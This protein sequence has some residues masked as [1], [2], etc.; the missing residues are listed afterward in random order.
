MN[1]RTATLIPTLLILSFL[2]SSLPSFADTTDPSGNDTT[3]TDPTT[4]GT[5]DTETTDAEKPATLSAEALDIVGEP[6]TSP[7]PTD[8]APA[9]DIVEPKPT[10]N[11]LPESPTGTVQSLVTPSNTLAPETSRTSSPAEEPTPGT[12]APTPVSPATPDAPTLLGSPTLIGAGLPQDGILVAPGMVSA[13]FPSFQVIAISLSTA[14]T[15]TVPTVIISEVQT[16]GTDAGGKI[17]GADEFIELY[18]PGNDVA[19][20]AGLKLCRKTSGTTTSQI[21]SFSESDTI[22]GKG[23]FLFANSDGKFAPKADTATKSSPLAKDNGIA[24]T[25]NCSSPT[26]I[27]DSLAWGTGKSF[28]M[29]TPRMENPPA[30]KSLVRDVETLTWSVSDCP[31]PTNSRGETTSPTDVC[32]KPVPPPPV[33]TVIISEL[34]PNPDTGGE[35]WIEIHNTGSANVSLAGWKLVDAIGKIY[36]FPKGSAIE[37]GGF[38]VV[39]GKTS[40]I[41]LNNDKETVSLLFPDESV[42]DTFQYVQTEK[43]ESWAR[44]D[45]GTFL[46]THTPTPGTSNMFD[47]EEKPI[48]L[49]DAGTIIVNEFLPYPNASEEEWI[50]LR[51]T[52]DT[53]VSIAGWKLKDASVSGG[54][55]F[56][57]MTTIGPDGYL[58]IG[59]DISK[60][61]LNNTGAES[62]TLSFPD[63]SATDTYSY[64]G[65]EQGAAYARTDA[66]TFLLTHT[67]TPGTENAFDPEEKPAW[68]PPVGTIIISELF[69]NPAQKGEGNEWIELRNTGNVPVSLIGWMLQSGSGKFTWTSGL[70][71]TQ[72]GIVADGFLVIERALSKLAL[73]NTD[74][75]VTLFAPGGVTTMDTVTYSKTIEEASYGFFGPGRFRWSKTP[76]PGAENIF[77]TEPKVKRSSIPRSGYVHALIPFSADGNKKN[78]KYS[79]DFGDGHRSYLDT[80]GH[81]YAK[82]GTY[83]GTLTASDGIEE[84][85]KTF[86][87]RIGRYPKWDVHLVGLCPNPSGTDTGSEWIRIRNDDTKRISLAGWSIATATEK[88]KLV[89]HV[90]LSDRSIAPGEEIVLTHDDSRFT[91]PNERAVIELRR[92][93][94]K[95]VQT[96]DYIRDG[97]AEDD[98]IFAKTSDSG[99]AWSVPAAETD[100]LAVEMAATEEFEP[101][102][103]GMT[104]DQDSDRLTFG[105]FVSLG[106]PYDP[107]LP[108]SLPRVL[109]ASDER[110]KDGPSS[111][112]SFIDALFRMLNGLATG[113]T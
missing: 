89:N 35:E 49:P 110:L 12:P 41:A 82:T 50:E 29:D 66:G 28:D 24:L 111:S 112:E 79:W 52:S 11:P 77:G 7:T 8:P 59:A 13:I 39:D 17:I 85:V 45:A 109:G 84:T 20:L 99:W 51:N 64:E 2:V 33:G 37:A 43:N 42:A 105:E 91:L 108:D 19:P 55:T 96:V 40:G 1:G 103:T 75:A 72:S 67:P 78:M 6:A 26:R 87:I 34:F 98:A 61:A 30:D 4:G 62:I 14:D 74:G 10:G 57:P 27:I 73:R 88:E 46:L 22:P 21:K 56:P 90:V 70:S 44:T 106:T 38:L 80:T 9:H 81:R 32:L 86:T 25:D 95:T 48:P 54:Y 63:G 31:T 92:P 16:E 76:T 53:E 101:Y 36:P 83:H 113:T 94:G 65:T 5:T 93:D 71:A 60:I 107:A 18:N 15:D 23:Y 47:P 69:P 58:V 102:E 104:S 3:A 68:V 97:G 100:P